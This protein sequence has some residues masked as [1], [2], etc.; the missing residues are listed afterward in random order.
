MC[1]KLQKM[2]VYHQLHLKTFLEDVANEDRSVII[3]KN[4]SEII[5]RSCGITS[6]I[7]GMMLFI[8]VGGNDYNTLWRQIENYLIF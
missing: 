8:H 1:I 5:D 3:C 4:V 6:I 2:S 7:S